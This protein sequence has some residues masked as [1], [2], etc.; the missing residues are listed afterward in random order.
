MKSIIAVAL[1]LLFCSI[2]HSAPLG[3]TIW[4]PYPG[5]SAQMVEQAMAAKAIQEKLGATV[6]I[7]MENTGRMH[8]AVAGFE[9]WQEWAKWVAKLQAS[10]EWTSWQAKSLADPA[11]A[12]EENYLLNVLPGANGGG[13]VY[14]VFI[15]DPRDGGVGRLVEVAQQA[16]AI[17]EKSG[18]RVSINVDQMQRM[19]YVMDYDNLD[20]WAKMQDTPNEEFSAFM[21]KQSANPTG[22]LIE[23][24]TANRLP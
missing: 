10:E 3:V 8:Y 11:S 19:H 20:H 15:W 12:Q 5:K 4:K 9:T 13:G 6:T 16:K 17:H 1:L 14:Q 24:Y 22:D 2:A 21:E 7:A 23:V 18:I